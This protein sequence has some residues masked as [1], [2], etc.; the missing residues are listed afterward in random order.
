[1][2]HPAPSLTLNPLYPPSHLHQLLL[3]GSYLLRHRRILLHPL[4]PQL[5]L[6]TRQPPP[7]PPLFLSFLPQ[8]ALLR[9]WVAAA[10][11]IGFIIATACWGVHKQR[12]MWKGRVSVWA[13]G[14][15]R[16]RMKYCWRGL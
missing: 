14:G 15:K 9:A 7:L 6:H 12:Q 3:P 8:P 10:G 13:G 2:L 4:L 1:M 16:V 11:S 5:A